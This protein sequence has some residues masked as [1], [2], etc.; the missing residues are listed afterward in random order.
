MLCPS[1]SVMRLRSRRPSL[2]AFTLIELLTV[3]A[4]IGILAAIIIPVVGKARASATRAQCVSHLRQIGIAATLFS[5]D[6]KGR[7]V[8]PVLKGQGPV[9]DPDAR[10]IQHTKLL[11]SYMGVA[12]FTSWG[13]Y[14]RTDAMNCRGWE[15]GRPVPATADAAG[16]A[17][18][19]WVFFNQSVDMKNGTRTN[20]YGDGTAAGTISIQ[21]K[22]LNDIQENTWMLIEIDGEMVPG[23]PEL[24][25]GGPMLGRGVPDHPPH[26]AYRN[27]LYFDGH[28]GRLDLN[29]NKI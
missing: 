27:V 18:C 11:G 12:P 8:G 19:F 22:L 25:L 15:S 10:R 29:Y 28:V 5:S 14:R 24:N 3:I 21:P 9:A 4:I 26:G 2:A 16:F 7:V 17:N 6:N 20:P 1:S 23:R 13:E